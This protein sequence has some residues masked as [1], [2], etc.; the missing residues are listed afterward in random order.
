[1]IGSK[2]APSNCR[3]LYSLYSL[4][5]PSPPPDRSHRP[6]ISSLASK[7]SDCR[8][9]STSESESGLPTSAQPRPGLGLVWRHLRHLSGAACLG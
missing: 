4:V 3:Y 5:A 8:I 9:E 2:L 6:V 7:T 1:L